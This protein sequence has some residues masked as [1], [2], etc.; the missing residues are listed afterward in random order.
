MEVC[1]KWYM[2]T[3]LLILMLTAC[4]GLLQ[5]SRVPSEEALRSRVSAYWDARVQGSP[6]KA[7]ELLEPKAKEVTSLGAYYNRTNKSDIL[8]YEIQN[9]DMHL[10][11]NEA[12]VRLKRSFKIKPGAIPINVD[13]ILEQTSEDRWV[14]IDGKWYSAYAFPALNF[15]KSPGKRPENR[16]N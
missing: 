4:T 3:I 2:G 9:I 13:K 10:E 1:K 7:Y 8:S 11:D 5:T 16:P 6:E 12:M 14:F 15:L